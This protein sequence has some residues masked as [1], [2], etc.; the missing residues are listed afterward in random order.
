MLQISKNKVDDKRVI[1]NICEHSRTN[2]HKDFSKDIW[3]FR[4][5]MIVPV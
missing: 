1:F 2:R 5:F 4:Y 3:M